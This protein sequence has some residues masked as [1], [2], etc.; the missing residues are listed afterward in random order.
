MNN[1]RELLQVTA[2]R[3]GLINKNCCMIGEHEVSVIQS[4]ILY[5]VDRHHDPSIQQIAETLGMDIT[6][7]SRQVQT[8]IKKKLVIKTSSS[9]DR[10][11]SILR[12]TEE[13]DVVIASINQ[14]MSSYLNEVFS[15]MSE[16]ER[17]TV[18]NSLKLLNESMLKSKM[19]GTPLG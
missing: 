1:P 7:F 17:E 4:H 8:L 15:F 11:V 18:I 13:G 2:R 14:L 5:E 6:T 19:C 10:R 12:L 16:F 3:F 9:E